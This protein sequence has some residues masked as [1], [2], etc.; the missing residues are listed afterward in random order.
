MIL[1]RRCW[2]VSRSG[3]S[4][5]RHGSD[6]AGGSISKISPGAC[7]AF[8]FLPFGAMNGKLNHLT[9]TPLG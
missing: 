1:S 5:A 3:S 8:A 9:S 4:Q 2:G 6:S 7:C